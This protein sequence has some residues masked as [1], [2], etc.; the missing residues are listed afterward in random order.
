MR[1]RAVPTHRR[2]LEIQRGL[3]LG[4][5]DFKDAEGLRG[6][7]DALRDNL[8]EAQSHFEKRIEATRETLQ[9][10]E[11]AGGRGA[12]GAPRHGGRGWDLLARLGHFGLHSNDLAAAESLRG[13]G[14]SEPS[15]YA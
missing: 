9:K 1:K 8:S 13:R 6:T 14:G 10:R 2:L 11:A 4:L 12:A 15:R 5:T 7:L 3:D